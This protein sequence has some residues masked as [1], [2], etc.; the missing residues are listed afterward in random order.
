MVQTVEREGLTV[1]MDGLTVDMV[2]VPGRG[3]LTVG[4]AEPTVVMEGLTAESGDRG[5]LRAEK[6]DTALSSV[7]IDRTPPGHSPQM[8]VLDD[9]RGVSDCGVRNSGDIPCGLIAAAEQHR[10]VS[11][12]L[13]LRAST[14]PSSSGAPLTVGC[15]SPFRDGGGLCSGAAVAGLGGAAFA[16]AVVGRLGRTFERAF[17]S[18][19]AVSAA[20]PAGVTPTGRASADGC[21]ASSGLAPAARGVA[22]ADGGASVF[23]VWS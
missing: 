8:D 4:R 6:E 12:G 20:G 22:R 13:G 9:V 16:L 3:V 19:A 1:V 5:E 18:G 17:G 7:S 23:E 14:K 2:G 10:G 21:G 11:S 15:S